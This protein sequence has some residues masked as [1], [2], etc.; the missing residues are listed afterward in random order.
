M[1][2]SPQAKHADLHETGCGSKNQ[3]PAGSPCQRQ[4]CCCQCPQ[5][6]PLLQRTPWTLPQLP[7]PRC[8]E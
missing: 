4:P 8:C 5:D 2:R 7:Q 1:L 3:D 6:L